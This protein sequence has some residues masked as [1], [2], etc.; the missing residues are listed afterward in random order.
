[1]VCATWCWN[2]FPPEYQEGAINIQEDNQEQEGDG[3]SPAVVT[4]QSTKGDICESSEE[5]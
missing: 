2:T 1:M 5:E 4:E 3:G